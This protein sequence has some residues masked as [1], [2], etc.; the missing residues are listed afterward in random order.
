M[1]H[2]NMKHIEVVQNRCQSQQNNHVSMQFRHV[3]HYLTVDMNIIVIGLYEYILTFDTIFFAMNVPHHSPWS[4]GLGVMEEYAWPRCFKFR[5]P[6]SSFSNT[7]LFYVRPSFFQS[8]QG[9]IRYMCIN[10]DIVVGLCYKLLMRLSYQ[11]HHA[12]RKKIQ[13]PAGIEPGTS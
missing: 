7:Y 6:P 9:Q 5:V 2:F 1:I 10:H 13:T 8:I 11:I 4:R 3:Y 12:Y